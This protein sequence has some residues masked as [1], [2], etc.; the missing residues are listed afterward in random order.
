MI[1][2]L[3]RGI[4]IPVHQSRTDTMLIPALIFAGTYLVVA[5]GRLPFLKLDRTGAAL[6]GAS[7]MVATGAL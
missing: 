1:Q 5:F 7:L 4:A 3:P 2:R 6:I